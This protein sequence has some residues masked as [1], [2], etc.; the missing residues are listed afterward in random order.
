MHLQAR[1]DTCADV[2]SMPASVYH[3]VFKD[4]KM[5]KLVSCKLQIGTYTANIIKIIG[6][7]TFYVVHLDSKKLVQVTFYVAT[8]DGSVLLSCK[9]TLVLHL[10]QPRSQLDYLAP[11][12]SLITSTMDHPKKTRP[13]PLTVHS[14]KQKVS[15]QSHQQEV[16][17]QMQKVQVQVTRPVSTI[18]I[19]KKPGMKKLVTSKEQMLTSYPDVFE[20]IGRFLGSPYH[21]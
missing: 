5:K 7:C 21:I 6:S 19:L 17:T 18:I 14:S 13:A 10:I 16:S 11:R 3:L 2:N 1:L 8:N 4:P 12:T 9:T 20:G 15:T